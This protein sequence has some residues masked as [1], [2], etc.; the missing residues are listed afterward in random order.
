LLETGQL[1]SNIG[2]DWSEVHF[3]QWW[4]PPLERD[5]LHLHLEVFYII[6]LSLYRCIIL[7][8]FFPLQVKINSYEGAMSSAFILGLLRMVAKNNIKGSRCENRRI[9][10]GMFG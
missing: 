2:P 10:S 5:F 7:Y 1:V 3:M 8:I 6:L 9:K 4:P